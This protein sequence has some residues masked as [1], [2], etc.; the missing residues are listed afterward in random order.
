METWEKSEVIYDGKVVRL[1]TG[2]VRLKNGRT[3]FREVI[4]HSGGV[5]VVPF[6]G[7]EVILVKQYRIALEQYLLEAPA[8]KLEAGDASPEYRGAC[9]VEEETGHRPERMVSAGYAYSTVGYSSEVIH[10]YLAFDL[11]GT[12]QRLD[13]EEDIEVVKMPL[14]E[15]RRQLAAH[16]FED[17]KTVIALHALLQHLDAQEKG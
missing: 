17:G 15:V 4:E 3:A 2:E 11:A 13:D 1:R 5:C 8:G 7:K 12:S 6:N 14:D 9:E 10:Y 16:E